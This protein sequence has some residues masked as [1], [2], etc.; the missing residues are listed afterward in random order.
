VVDVEEARR[1]A[2]SRHGNQPYADGLYTDH[3]AAAVAV[4]TRFGVTAPEVLAAI[5]LHDVIEDTVPADD[6]AAQAALRHELERRFGSRTAAL[7]WAVTDRPG[8]NRR[9]RAALTYPAIAAEPGATQV[10]LADRI[11]NVEQGVATSS[12][13]LR[14][15]LEEQPGFR[16]A[17][18]RDGQYEELWEHLDGLIAEAVSRRATSVASRP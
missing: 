6:T 12:P 8:P 10:K 16:E 18:R 11:A 4:A 9:A 3:L 7:V 2:A 5:W 14:M 1:F 15:Y 17:L 13:R